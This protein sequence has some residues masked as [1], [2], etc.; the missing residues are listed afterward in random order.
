MDL[1]LDNVR[2]E[3]ADQVA[4]VTLDRPPVNALDSQTWRAAG[5]RL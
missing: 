2:V 3:V 1:A 5:D 4:V